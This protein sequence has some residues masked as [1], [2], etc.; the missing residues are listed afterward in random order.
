MPEDGDAASATRK[1]A[2]PIHDDHPDL[3]RLIGEGRVVAYCGYGSLVNKR[4]LRT[5]FLAI[6]PAAVFGWRRFWLPR[7]GGG[8]ALLSVRP[9]EGHETHGVV[10]YDHAD[11][12]P[13]VDERE[14]GYHRRVV[15]PD[16]VRV[17]MPPPGAVPLFIY[18]A[19]RGEADAA[20]KGGPILQSY[21]D[22][23]LQ[24]FLALYGE[25]GVR[26]FVTETDGFETIVLRDRERP[27]YPRA[28]QLR[29]G[30]AVL[31]DRLVGE[32]GAR[33]AD[34]AN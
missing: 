3:G 23:V 30:E 7:P 28:V 21:L 26:R 10:V 19:A 32:R 20:E 24:G 2:A 29:E 5:A 9:E 31:F 12:L 22:A 6:R 13:S 27:S 4:T 17:E 16:R 14:A 25:E 15:A 8:P 11:H 33:F 1:S 34:P 18:E